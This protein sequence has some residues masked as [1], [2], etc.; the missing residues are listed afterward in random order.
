MD[1]QNK[2]YINP[3]DYKSAIVYDVNG[4]TKVKSALDHLQDIMKQ[5]MIIIQDKL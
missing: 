3:V 2:V 5:L 1:G 4:K